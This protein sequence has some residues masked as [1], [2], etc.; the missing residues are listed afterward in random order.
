MIR[1]ANGVDMPGLSGTTPP[2]P[3]FLK[4]PHLHPSSPTAPPSLKYTKTCTHLL[5]IY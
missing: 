4:L 5:P 1:G 3:T 2:H